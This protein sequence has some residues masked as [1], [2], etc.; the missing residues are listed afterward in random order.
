MRHEHVWTQDL[1]T[2]ADGGVDPEELGGVS[3]GEEQQRLQVQSLHQQPG[4]VQQDA[5]VEERHRG[6]TPE[7][8]SETKDAKWV[9][10]QHSVHSNGRNKSAFL[11]HEDTE[12]LMLFLFL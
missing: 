11:Q 9:F 6:L 7:L 2:P 4:E 12:D 5:P 3:E 10:V 1:R 8:R